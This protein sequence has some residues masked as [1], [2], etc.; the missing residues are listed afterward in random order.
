MIMHR[1]RWSYLRTPVGI[2]W[3]VMSPICLLEGFL[4]VTDTP[5]WIRVSAG[6]VLLITII[7]FVRGYGRR[8]ELHEEGVRWRSL[9]IRRELR[10]AD[11][12]SVGT[13]VPGGGVGTTE[14]AYLSTRAGPPVGKWEIDE[15]TFQV[16]N[17]P[18]VIEAIEAFRSRA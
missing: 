17:R 6:G 1:R 3:L 11:I 18:G 9:L 7:A 14:Y 10:W 16:Q 15:Q 2:Y 4:L 8:I 13:Y 12:T 5:N